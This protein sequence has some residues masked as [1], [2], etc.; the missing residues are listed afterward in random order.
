MRS[1][2]LGRPRWSMT[3]HAYAPWPDALPVHPRR[4]AFLSA[5]RT[6]CAFRGSS[7]TLKAAPATALSQLFGLGSYRPKWML[8]ARSALYG[9]P[10]QATCK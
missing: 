6:K 3:A 5:V 2:D 9:M 4:R 8:A 1:V 7:S 10:P